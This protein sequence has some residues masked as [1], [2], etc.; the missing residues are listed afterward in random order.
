MEQMEQNETPASNIPPVQPNK[1]SSIGPIVGIVIIVA[2]LILG[3]L[4]YWGSRLNDGAGPTGADIANM[5]DEALVNLATQGSSD[6]LGAIE[7]DLTSTD[8]DNLDEELNLA[9]DE[10]NSL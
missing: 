10:L 5:P 6:T 1:S 8:L 2:V 4:Y 3:G 9:E 7:D